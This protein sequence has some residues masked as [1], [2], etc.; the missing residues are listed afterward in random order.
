MDASWNE[1]K[2]KKAVETLFEAL[3]AARLNLDQMSE[4][5]MVKLKDLLE[6]MLNKVRTEREKHQQP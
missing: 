6:N 2:N 3:A 5:E 4:E 1:S